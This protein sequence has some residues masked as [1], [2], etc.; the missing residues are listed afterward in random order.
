M[1][2]AITIDRAT[3]GGVKVEPAAI[4]IRKV[5]GGGVSIRVPGSSGTDST[6]L[7]TLG[8]RHVGGEGL[9]IRPNAV[10]VGTLTIQAVALDAWRGKHDCRASASGAAPSDPRTAPTEES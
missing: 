5:G 10:A 4:T 8:A 3:V 2:V 7:F 1:T 6:D 9:T